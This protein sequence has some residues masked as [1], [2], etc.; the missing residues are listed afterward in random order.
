MRRGQDLATPSM[1]FFDRATLPFHGARNLAHLPRRRLRVPG[2]PPPFGSLRPW[3]DVG[4]VGIQFHIESY[5][6]HVE[7]IELKPDPRL[8]IALEPRRLRLAHVIPA[9]DGEYRTVR[10]AEN[11]RNCLRP[12]KFR[13]K[14]LQVEFECVRSFIFCQLNRPDDGIG[15]GIV[16]QNAADKWTGEGGEPSDSC[17]GLL[18]LAGLW[19]RPSPP[20][21]PAP[22]GP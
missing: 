13:R 16:D 21:P 7:T 4:I 12:P 2:I 1:G 3:L 6:A 19:I 17:H 10:R 9:V 11:C 15:C 14:R 5:R 18:L 22:G 20:R 8:L